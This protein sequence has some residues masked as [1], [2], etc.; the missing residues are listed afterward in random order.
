MSGRDV[1][2]EEMVNIRGGYRLNQSTDSLDVNDR[3]ITRAPR[4]RMSGR[5]DDYMGAGAGWHDWPGVGRSGVESIP[6]TP[7]ESRSNT[8]SPVRSIHSS[9]FF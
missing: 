8:P 9:Q 3:F 4:A 2:E 6:D 7:Y 5:S 1:Y